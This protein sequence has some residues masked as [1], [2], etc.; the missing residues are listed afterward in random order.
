MVNPIKSYSFRALAVLRGVDD[1]DDDD[2]DYVMWRR[3]EESRVFL[4]FLFQW[5]TPDNCIFF[6]N[7]NEESQINRLA[8]KLQTIL[9][10]AKQKCY[11]YKIGRE[12]A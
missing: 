8:Y 9:L 12:R 11:M 1:D 3:I 4:A 2:D 5:P 10:R 7:A 6:D